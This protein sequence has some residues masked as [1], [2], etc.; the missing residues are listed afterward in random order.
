MGHGSMARPPGSEGGHGAPRIRERTWYSC[1]ALVTY[2]M[3]EGVPLPARV[4]ESGPVS[5]GESRAGRRHE[6]RLRPGQEGRWAGEEGKGRLV[7]TPSRRGLGLREGSRRRPCPHGIPDGWGPS[8]EV[9]PGSDQRVVE[10]PALERL[11]VVGPRRGGHA[12]V[13]VEQDAHAAHH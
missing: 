7:L 3:A 9:P 13:G 10:L 4:S 6:V 2:T 5:R 11:L 12:A 1:S 8:E